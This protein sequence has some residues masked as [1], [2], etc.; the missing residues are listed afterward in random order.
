MVTFDPEQK[1]TLATP[2]DELGFG[3]LS[4]GAYRRRAARLEDVGVHTRA[5]WDPHPQDLSLRGGTLP[6]SA[7]AGAGERL[8]PPD[9]RDVSDPLAGG[10][11]RGEWLQGLQP[12]GTRRRQSGASAGRVGPQHARALRWRSPR[13]AAGVPHRGR[14]G[15]CTEPLFPGGADFRRPSRGRRALHPAGAGGRSHDRAGV[16]G[17]EHSSWPARR[18]RAPGVPGTQDPVEPRRGGRPPR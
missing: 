12:G 17:G 11:A 5:G 18:A 7:P 9:S 16:S 13:G 1:P 15:R 2:F 8:G 4:R 6:V 3:D 10:A 14:L